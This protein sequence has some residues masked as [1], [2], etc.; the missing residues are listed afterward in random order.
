M[1][2][3]A[4]VILGLMWFFIFGFPVLILKDNFYITMDLSEI[5]Y[6]TGKY[7]GFVAYFIFF[8]QYLWTAKVQFIESLFPF[9]TRV[10]IHRSLGFIGILTLT[11][12]P[13]LILSY[14]A[15]LGVSYD[16]SIPLLLGYLAFFLVII[17]G[18]STF[19][20]KMFSVK[21]E[22]WK[23]I[24]N[25]SFFILTLAFF[26]ALLIGSDIYSIYRVVWITIWV[27]HIIL[28]LIKFINKFRLSRKIYYVHKVIKENI[29]VTTIFIKRKFKFKAGQFGFISLFID[30][31]WEYW[32]PFSISSPVNESYISFTIK[33][34][35]DF[36][37]RV[38]EVKAGDKIKLDLPYGGFTTANYI[39]DKYTFIAGGVGIT[40]IFSIISTISDTHKEKDITLLYSV[41]NEQDILFRSELDSTFSK[42]SMWTLKYIMSSQK[43]W[44]GEKGRLTPDR[45]KG[46][47]NNKLSGTYF[48][49]GPLGM[50]I[51]LKKYLIKQGI[52]KD[53]VRSEQFVFI[54]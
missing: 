40:P 29:N 1:N 39:D 42:N 27:L 2:K 12:H 30:G 7:L 49:C 15:N 24:H 50:I 21:Y 45:L 17:I 38:P 26:H 41:H 20:G 8:L 25:I 28:V 36:T 53:R 5:I 31:K 3:K 23:L 35:G 13:I 11:L 52:S 6:I 9:D 16:L 4:K 34:L 33:N 46:L 22:T 14:Y 18:G 32:H 44:S 48:L 10:G 47:C 54:P 37:S 51:G 19:L 43:D